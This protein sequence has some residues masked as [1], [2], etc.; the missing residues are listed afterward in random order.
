M[1]HGLFPQT[2]VD[3]KVKNYGAMLL[4]GEMSEQLV[5]IP[6]GERPVELYDVLYQ[7]FRFQWHVVTD[8]PK[9]VM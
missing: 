3:S 7:F 8:F 9:P 1:L 2:S 5:R 6:H 4:L